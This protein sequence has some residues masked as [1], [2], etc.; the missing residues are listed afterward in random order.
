M[1]CSL[2]RLFSRSHRAFPSAHPFS[3]TL[4]FN[5]TSFYRDCSFHDHTIRLANVSLHQKRCSTW[6]T[7]MIAYSI[8]LRRVL[9]RGLFGPKSKFSGQ[10]CL[11]KVNVYLS[12]SNFGLAPALG[13]T[14]LEEQFPQTLNRNNKNL[15]NFVIHPVLKVW[16]RTTQNRI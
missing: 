15:T 8:A 13:C 6:V 14:Y 11:Q 1:S 7:L 10:Q 5:R 9:Y 12:T 4:V 3:V 2:V 16:S